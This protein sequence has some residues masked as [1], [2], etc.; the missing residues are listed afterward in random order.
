LLLEKIGGFFWF[1]VGILNLILK[2]KFGIIFIFVGDSFLFS[3]LFGVLFG[4]VWLK[5][6]TED[7]L[8]YGILWNGDMTLLYC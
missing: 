1:L 3:G 2:F 5:R 6:K 4:Y 8:G 7:I